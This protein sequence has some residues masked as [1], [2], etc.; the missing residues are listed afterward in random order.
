MDEQFFYCPVCGNLAHMAIASGVTPI[1]CS[2]EMLALH[3]KT[4]EEGNEHHLPV[5]ECLGNQY[6]C[7]KVG[8][9]PHPVTEQ[10]RICIICLKTTKEF[11]MRR[12]RPG[13]PAEA[14]FRFRGRPLCVYSFCNIHGLWCSEVPPEIADKCCQSKCTDEKCNDNKEKRECAHPMT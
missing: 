6:V 8:R 12:L 5:V 1:C 14:K 7:V 13:H 11:I 3:P 2:E 10:H 4:S 9:T